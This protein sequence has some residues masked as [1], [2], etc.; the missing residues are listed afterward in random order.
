MSKSITAL[1]RE[2][3]VRSSAG[4]CSFRLLKLL[5]KSVAWWVKTHVNCLQC[6]WWNK[7]YTLWHSSYFTSW[8]TQRRGVAAVL[9][10]QIFDN[11]GVHSFFTSENWT[12]ETKTIQHASF[13]RFRAIV[14][15]FYINNNLLHSCI[16]CPY[17]N[18]ISRLLKCVIFIFFW[19]VKKGLRM[20]GIIECDLS[21]WQMSK[22]FK[23]RQR[24][25]VV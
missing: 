24:D 16:K 12:G 8:R 5:H 19:F 9:P 25:A 7:G 14:Y 10:F 20:K 23:F 22:S 18:L 2:T 3:E 11:G 17:E 15:F 6:C 1:M 13:C 4:Y 21:R